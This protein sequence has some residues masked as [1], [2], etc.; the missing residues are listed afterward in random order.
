MGSRNDLHQPLPLHL[1]LDQR[2]LG[3]QGLWPCCQGEGA[4]H[5]GLSAAETRLQRAPFIPLFIHSFFC[6]PNAL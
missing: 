3:C 4:L 6:S 2:P 5:P 1:T